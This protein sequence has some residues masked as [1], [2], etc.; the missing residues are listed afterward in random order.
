[1]F[2]S[3]SSSDSDDAGDSNDDDDDCGACSN[4][5]ST[6]TIGSK[7]LWYHVSELYGES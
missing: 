2:V 6:L 7:S 4:V 3:S 1:M 5:S